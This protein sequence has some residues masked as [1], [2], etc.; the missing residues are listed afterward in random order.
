MLW[1]K[2]TSNGVRSWGEYARTTRGHI[3]VNDK[4]KIPAL[5]G[6]HD[7][8]EHPT[9]QRAFQHQASRTLVRGDPI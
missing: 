8:L 9:L 5:H 6:V 7:V 3:S 1:Q 2:A 4:Q